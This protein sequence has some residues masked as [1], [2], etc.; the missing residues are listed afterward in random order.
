MKATILTL[1]FLLLGMTVQAQNNS[2]FQNETSKKWGVKD[3]TTGKI[4]TE[5]KYDSYRS[6]ENGYAVAKWNNKEDII[7]PNGKELTNFRYDYVGYMNKDGLIAVAQNGKYGYI[8]L[9]LQIIIPLTF[10]YAST[11]A[12]G[13]AEVKQKIGNLW[14]S[15]YINTQG[16]LVVP[17][18]YDKANLF[19]KG[20]GY[21]RLND[22]AGA[23]DKSGNEVVSPKYDILGLFDDEVNIARV[24][25]AGKVG[26]IHKSGKE[27]TPLQYELA[28]ASFYHGKAEVVL[29]GRKFFIDKNGNDL[30]Q[31]AVA[32]TTT[33]ATDNGGAELQKAQIASQTK[34]EDEAISWYQKAA[35]KGNAEAMFQLGSLYYI[36]NKI[37]EAKKWLQK[38]AD[39][40]STGA[41]SFLEL[42]KNPIPKND[43]TEELN[44]S[45]VAYKAKNYT[46]TINW[47]KKA[48]DKGNANAMFV[49]AS[50]YLHGDGVEKNEPEGKKWLQKAAEKGNTLAKTTLEKFQ[51]AQTTTSNDNGGADYEKGFDAEM[52]KNYPEAVKWYQLSA[53]KGN[54]KG[55]YGLGVAYYKGRGIAKNE[56]EGIVLLQKA[57]E[58]GDKWASAFLKNINQQTTATNTPTK[59][60]DDGAA[61]FQKGVVLYQA[62]NYAEAFPLLKKASEKGQ[63]KAMIALATMYFTGLGVT[64]N[65]TEAF[66][67]YKK[68]AEKGEA[69]AM[70][71]LGSMYLEGI[72]SIQNKIEAQNW[73]QKS[74]DKGYEKAKTALQKMQSQTAIIADNGNEE[75]TK[76]V[77][78]H[79]EKKYAEAMEWYKKAADKGNHYAL[80]NIGVMHFYGLGVAVDEGKAAVYYLRA[81][82]KNNPRANQEMAY[83]TVYG[84]GNVPQDAK[85]AVSYFNNAVKLGYEQS[86]G[87]QQKIQKSKTETASIFTSAKKYITQ[88]NIV[89]AISL[90]EQAADK[91]N[92]DAMYELA[93]INNQNNNYMQVYFWSYMGT[94]LYD[95]NCIT[96]FNKISIEKK[97]ELYFAFSSIQ[98]DFGG[99]ANRIGHDYQLKKDKINSLNWFK[100]S[101]SY[102]NVDGATMAGLILYEQKDFV[103]AKRYFEQAKKLGDA[104]A[105]IMLKEI[106]K[107]GKN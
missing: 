62:K 31:N 30:S 32:S 55:M 86:V 66:N 102:D 25:F 87:I 98:Y 21:V 47:L 85:K 101:A 88:K 23:V 16:K 10:D 41:N 103:S 69:S 107:N 99:L 94:D 15:G 2:F 22:K 100:R 19:Y 27:I 45:S 38:A 67:W 56:R 44:K 20:L 12:E 91:G 11:F 104:T 7:D 65:R 50:M 36:S 71:M 72:G 58:K 90:L 61:E 84:L 51:L 48:I 29:N 82:E 59:T 106:E 24:V 92:T 5:P 49:L 43:G 37:P 57:A 74:A 46:E 54:E 35:D 70:Y 52:A 78:L 17:Y 63:P 39:K 77:A 3:K 105:D 73:L 28:S 83:M 93:L 80:S 9:T 96:L 68:S 6:E 89:A 34:N 8:N 53:N 33:K 26:Y 13:M 75:N 97:M 81:A 79:K 60:I 95:E 18:R 40:G 42:L 4:V 76:G 64:E 1:C 14:K